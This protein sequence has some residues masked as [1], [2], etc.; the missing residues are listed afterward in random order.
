MK[1]S[2]DNAANT[3]ARSGLPIFSAALLAQPISLAI[4][5]LIIKLSGVFWLWGALVFLVVAPVT[6]LALIGLAHMRSAKTPPETQAVSK[7]SLQGSPEF[8]A[9]KPLR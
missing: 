7:Q 5:A 9:E 3:G 1:H 8:S 4:T 6:V 2:P